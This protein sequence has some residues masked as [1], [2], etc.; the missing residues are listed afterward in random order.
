M[1]SKTQRSIVRN[2]TRA[3][4]IKFI[5][6]RFELYFY[7]SAESKKQIEILLEKGNIPDSKLNILC[8]WLLEEG[9]LPNKIHEFK[10]E[11]PAPK[12]KNIKG[13]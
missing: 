3:D 5:T 9:Y 4:K 7:G 10:I 13:A 1:D 12:Y 6:A 8:R 11:I 2:M